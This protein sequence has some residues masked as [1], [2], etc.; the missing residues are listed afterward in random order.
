MTEPSMTGGVTVSLANVTPERVAW[1]WPGRLPLGKIVVLDGDP[2][3]GKSTTA[4]DCAA[5]VSTGTAWPDGA[6]NRRGSVLLLSAEDGLADT[7][8]PRRCWLGESGERPRDDRDP[9]PGR[10]R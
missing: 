1:L 7:I 4:V 10:K 2:S 5:R 3:V 8:R 6:A 9:L